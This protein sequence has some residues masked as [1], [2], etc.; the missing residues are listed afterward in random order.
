[1]SFKSAYVSSCF[2][3]NIFNQPER[4]EDTTGLCGL[5]KLSKS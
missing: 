4:V 3:Q 2:S 1:M 5:T